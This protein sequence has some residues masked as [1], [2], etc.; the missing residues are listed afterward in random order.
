M[1]L[2]GPSVRTEGGPST[3]EFLVGLDGAGPIPGPSSD[4]LHALFYLS[5]GAVACPGM[6][7]WFTIYA[8]CQ[9]TLR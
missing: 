9:L 8:M 7:S 2:R 6:A 1:H 3:R 5:P 4:A